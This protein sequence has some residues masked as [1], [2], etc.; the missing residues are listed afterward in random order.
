MNSTVNA[1]SVV[2]TSSSSDRL[3][4]D[5]KNHASLFRMVYV[6]FYTLQATSYVYKFSFFK[7]PKL[8]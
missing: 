3:A 5:L 6:Y 7:I 1:F 4:N 2:Q 8:G